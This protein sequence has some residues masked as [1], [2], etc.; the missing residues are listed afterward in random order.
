MTTDRVPVAS[1]AGGATAF[2]GESG[3]V[4]PVPI[5]NTEV[6]PASADGT[7][8]ET[9]WESRTPPDFSLRA[10]PSG[11]ARS[12]FWARLDRGP[13]GL[14]TPRESGGAGASVP[15]WLR[16]PMVDLRAPAG[17]AVVRRAVE[18]SGAGRAAGAGPDSLERVVVPMVGVVRVGASRAVVL[19]VG[20]VVTVRAEDA[21]VNGPVAVEGT[22]MS[23]RRSGEAWLVVVRAGSIARSPRTVRVAMHGGP[24]SRRVFRPWRPVRTAYAARPRGPSNVP[25]P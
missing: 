7:W 17:E 13:E 3:G 5:P 1:A 10:R 12:S 19:M 23:A 2:G 22:R 20:V 11:L 14:R 6:K 4:T 21:A 9:P 18:P 8:A 15:S 24:S 25:A 16:L